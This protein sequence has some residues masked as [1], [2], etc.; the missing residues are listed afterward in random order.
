MLSYL[1]TQCWRVAFHPLST[2]HMSGPNL[3]APIS[4]SLDHIAVRASELSEHNAEQRFAATLHFECDLVTGNRVPP[5]GSVQIVHTRRVS[6]GSATCES[7]LFVHR[8]QCWFCDRHRN[9]M[10]RNTS[11]RNFSEMEGVIPL[12]LTQETDERCSST[13]PEYT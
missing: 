9:S 11:I 2:C 4:G 13:P 10:I 5:P 3:R 7:L 6:V 1:P 12:A 8:K